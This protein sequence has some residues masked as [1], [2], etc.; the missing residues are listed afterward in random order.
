MKRKP[1]ITSQTLSVT[2]T[3]SQLLKKIDLL[4][5]NWRR[6]SSKND[7]SS[8][9][10][11]PLDLSNLISLFAKPVIIFDIYD[12]KCLRLE[13]QKSKTIAPQVAFEAIIIFEI[14]V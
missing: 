11:V 8:K 9:N 3:F 6:T 2:S 13:H 5:S 1:N 4:T 12:K 10:L 7:K 14:R